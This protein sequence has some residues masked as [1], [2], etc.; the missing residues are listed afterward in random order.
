MELKLQLRKRTTVW[1]TTIP[2]RLPILLVLAFI[3][4]TAFQGTRGL[5]KTTE[6]RY[7]ECAREMSQS[8]RWLE[9]VLNGQPHSLLVV[10]AMVAV[11][12][13]LP[14]ETKRQVPLFSLSAIFLF[15]VVGFGWYVVEVIKHPGLANY[16]LH[17]EVVARSFTKAS[18]RNPQI[19]KNFELYLPPPYLWNVFMER[20]ADLPLACGARSDPIDWNKET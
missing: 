5:C 17:D 18:H 19:F 6:G 4:V 12:V 13:H 14:R 16:W 1:L 2:L 7:A 11:W 20:L 9:P 10:P 15:L 8:G 3:A